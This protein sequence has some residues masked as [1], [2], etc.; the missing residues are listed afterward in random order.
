MSTNAS[1]SPFTHSDDWITLLE[2]GTT[3][4]NGTT[5]LRTWSASF[6]LA[7]YLRKHSGMIFAS[8]SESGRRLP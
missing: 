2:S 3:I 4:E 6:A 5:G 8:F 7:E 1:S